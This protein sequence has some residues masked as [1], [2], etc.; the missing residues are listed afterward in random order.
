M[1]EAT[2]YGS[3]IRLVR[4]VEVLVQDLLANVTQSL[5]ITIEDRSLSGSKF[6]R[7]IVILCV[8]R[9]CIAQRVF[10]V[11]MLNLGT[12][13]QAQMNTGG[14]I[15]ILLD[16]PWVG[17][18]TPEGHHTHWEPTNWKGEAFPEKH[19]RLQ[20]ANYRPGYSF[21]VPS[22]LLLMGHVCSRR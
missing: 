4:S 7:Y 22:G 21:G 11:E 16:Y 14:V 18:Q 6:W 17:K 15:G 12:K 10:H 3:Q 1:L 2:N 9:T 20:S 8:Y 19:D 13:I 5:P